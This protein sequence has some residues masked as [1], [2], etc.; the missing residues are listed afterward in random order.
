M[1]KMRPD[2]PGPACHSSKR[3][4]PYRVILF[5]CDANTCRSPMSEAMLKKMLVDLKDR[6]IPASKASK[7]PAEELTDKVVT[8]VLVDVEKPEYTEQY[9]KLIAKLSA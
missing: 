7:M 5:V 6:S 3:N 1:F 4:L 8:G 2:N 9:A